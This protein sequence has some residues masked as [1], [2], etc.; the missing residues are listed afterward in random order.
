[1]RRRSPGAVVRPRN[2]LRQY[3][4]LQ[5]EWWQP[6]GAF[7]MLHWIAAARARLVP[8]AVRA[9]SVLLDVG[10]G[11]G[12]LAPHVARLG[13]RHLGLDLVP[14]SV[15]QARAHGVEAVVGDA[16]RIP[17]RDGC[18]DV[19][20][21]G[22]VL[23]HVTDPQRV[24]AE[25]VRVLR[26][27]GTLVVD[28]IAATWWG[29][30]SAITIGERLPAGPPAR[31]HDARLFTDRDALVATCHRLGV[32]LTLTGLRPSAPDYLLWLAGRRDDV[33]MVPSRSTAGLFQAH[34]T[35]VAP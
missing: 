4:D 21:A 26:S 7:A 31:L 14:C 20:V 13:H 29:R 22:E 33:R 2:D 15:A 6:R 17:L 19:V 30:F 11:A 35:K 27:D 3:D 12:V 10:C 8:R 23:E 5:T 16:G 9:G 25:C 28:T 1:M 18:V 34:G 32:D 24:L